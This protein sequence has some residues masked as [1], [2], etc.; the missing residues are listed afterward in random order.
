MKQKIKLATTILLCFVV[1]SCKKEKTVVP[2]DISDQ[3]IVLGCSDEAALNY[4]ADA[5]MNEGC[6][7]QSDIKAEQ[8][9]LGIYFTSTGCP[10]CGGGGTAAFQTIVDNNSPDVIPISV[11]VKYGDPYILEESDELASIIGYGF[12]T[13]YY[14]IGEYDVMVIS[15]GTIHMSQVLT[16]AS[17]R[18]A[19]IVNNDPIISSTS[20]LVF[21]DTIL[22][23]YY[24]AEFLQSVEGQ[25][26]IAVYLLEDETVYPQSNGSTDPYYHQYVWSVAINGTIGESIV[27]NGSEVGQTFVGSKTIEFEKR[28]NAN[29]LY[30]ITVIWKDGEEIVN[31]SKSSGNSLL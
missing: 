11:H 13:P 7:Y 2:E 21:E 9:A 27:E 30:A 19:S 16:K 1:F 29:N 22:R 10:S 4:N 18:V 20:K 24:V 5:N 14:F 6:I 17:N 15:G 25:Y 3:P 28:W 8:K 31:V 26:S 23:V 12:Q